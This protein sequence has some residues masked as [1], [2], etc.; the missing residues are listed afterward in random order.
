MSVT[1]STPPRT[2]GAA[3]AGREV[4]DK[5]DKA[6]VCIVPATEAHR[7][8]ASPFFRR[9]SK[10]IHED[11]FCEIQLFYTEPN[12]HRGPARQTTRSCTPP[13]RRAR[14]TCSC[15][16]T[17]R[18]IRRNCLC[19]PT[20]WRI[21]RTRSCTPPPWQSRR[22]RLCTPPPWRSRRTR[23]CTP[24][25]WRR[26]R[27]RLSTPP[28]WVHEGHV[29]ARLLR[30]VHEGRICVRLVVDGLT[31]QQFS[32]ALGGFDGAD[33]FGRDRPVPPPPRTR[34]G[35]PIPTPGRSPAGPTRWPWRRSAV[36]PPRTVRTP[37]A[38]SRPGMESPLAVA[39]LPP[40]HRGDH[41]VCVGRFHVR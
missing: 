40:G 4:N 2:E 25:P 11:I 30:S 32:L 27:M 9:N 7:R 39:P 1:H 34:G 22:T 15:M 17:L 14:T 6:S 35:T 16:T 19:M 23:S 5:D 13:P 37:W 8:C 20:P 33:L 29:L 3:H 10:L 41:D 31:S 28:P 26:R 18:R 24:P 36:P 38:T 21:R 12:G